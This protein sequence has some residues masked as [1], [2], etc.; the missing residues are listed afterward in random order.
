MAFSAEKYLAMLKEGGASLALQINP[1]EIITAPWTIMK[2]RYGCPRYGHNRS[3]PPFAPSYKE[4]RAILDS[5]S[6]ALIFSIPDMSKGTPLAIK[7]MRSLATD[8][9]YKAL[10]FGTGPCT[11]CEKCMLSDCPQ[12]YD[13][14]PSMEACGIDVFGTVKNLGLPIDTN[15]Q[16]G[17]P[18]NCYGLILVE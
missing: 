1:C 7:L 6:I 13:V 10:A 17:K 4:T 18:L 15:P 16:P 3:C 2:C 8:G 14:A 9:Y 12:P 11:R 5:F